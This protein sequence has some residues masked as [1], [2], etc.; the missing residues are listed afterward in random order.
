MVDKTDIVNEEAPAYDSEKHTIIAL[1][2]E[3]GT[4]GFTEVPV[5]PNKIGDDKA[6][7]VKL[8]GTEGTVDTYIITMEATATTYS[9]TYV[10]ND[11]SVAG[12][13]PG[14]LTF[15]TEDT[16]AGFFAD[17]TA[18]TKI[19]PNGAYTYTFKGWAKSAEA[20]TVI[21]TT[22]TELMTTLLDEGSTT[23]TLYAI[24][25][26]HSVATPA[27]ITV[28]FMNGADTFA[29]ATAVDGKVSLPETN[30]TLT[31]SSGYA[32]TSYAFVGWVTA[33]GKEFTANTTVEEDTTVYPKFKAQI[34]VKGVVTDLINGDVNLDGKVNTADRGQIQLYYKQ[35]KGS[36]GTV[37]SEYLDAEKY[38]TGDID[39]NSKINTADRGQV[40]LYYKQGKG[41]AGTLFYYINK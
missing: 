13:T 27:D 1:D 29:T 33:D 35:G 26:E 23:L 4:N 31:A 22:S 20:T 18:P 24:Y 41:N 21:D 36:A 28:T 40:Q 14:A 7:V 32:A 9:V 19:D 17:V 15:G 34:T 16:I 12:D 39:A 6:I 5:D 2:Q 37:I 30:P 10:L 11:G 38:K 8:G 25:E 3:A